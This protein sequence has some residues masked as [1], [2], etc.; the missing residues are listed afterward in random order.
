MRIHFWNTFFSVFFLLLVVLGVSYLAEARLI[1]YDVPVRDLLLIALA[2]FRLVRLFTYDHIT[3]FIRDWFKD[4]PVN[5]LRH[6]LGALLNCLWCTGL[7]FSFLVVFCYFATPFSWPVILVLA[8]A[9]LASFFQVFTNLV[10]WSA[11]LKKLEAHSFGG[12][13]LPPDT[14]SKCG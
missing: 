11:Q 8:L 6:T 4:A 2:V 9:A 7:W 10:S 13:P 12:T 1:F 3:T 14:H 5:S